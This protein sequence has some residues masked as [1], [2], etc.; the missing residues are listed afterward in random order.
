VVADRLLDVDDRW[1]PERVLA[2]EPDAAA[3]AAGRGLASPSVWSSAGST[4]GAVWGLCQGS[5]RHPYRTI[6]DLSGPA[7]A[8]TCP[9]RKFPCKHALGLLLLWSSGAVTA[10]EAPAGF[11]AEWLARRATREPAPG[12]TRAGPVADPVAAA[13]RV[14]QRIARVTAGLEE[15]D[16]WLCDR[17]RTG[18]A[19]SERTGFAGV[20]QMAARMVDAQ[21]PGVAARL[22][23]LP[24]VL[25]SGEGWHAR[26]LEQ[27]A[28][29]RLLVRAHRDLDRL[30]ER[31]VVAVRAHVGYPVAKADVLA[32]P[33]VRDTWSVL[34]LRDQ[35]EDRLITRRVWL[36]G[37]SGRAAVVISFAP[38]GQELDASLLPGT[39]V[40]ASL[41]F[42]PGGS[43]AL[44]GERHGEP[45][46]LS[47]PAGIS[48][49]GALEGWAS[50]LAADPWTASHPV[51]LG[52]VAPVR[53]PAGRWLLRQP[54][55]ASL[56]LARAAGDPWTLVAVSAGEPV[57]VAGEWTAEGFVPVSAVRRRR[58]VAL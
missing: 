17:I 58:L 40:E 27:Y 19:G 13:R 3:A 42:Y 1:P 37:A 50:A 43:R 11:A 38:P 28:L 25:A 48:V 49:P 10:A 41:H 9:S 57:G 29:L 22:R 54:D 20:E 8:C 2:L 30:P 39:S 23:R 56:P 45:G 46:P 34:G 36:L 53:D 16:Q 5:G 12:A 26:L 21:A 14:E 31:L 7:Y 4:A 44:V 15:L 52:Q 32:G 33:A 24:G 47:A 55:S 35:E 18:L 6:V 51:L